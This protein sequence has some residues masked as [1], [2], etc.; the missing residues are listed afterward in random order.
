MKSKNLYVFLGNSVEGYELFKHKS[1]RFESYY[2]V[3]QDITG[4][5][6]YSS[7]TN[8][9]NF[10]NNDSMQELIMNLMP[11]K[12][13]VIY[14]LLQSLLIKDIEQELDNLLRKVFLITKMMYLPIIHYR[15]SKIWFLDESLLLIKKGNSHLAEKNSLYSFSAGLEVFIK[16]AAL[17][18]AKKNINVNLIQINELNYHEKLESLLSIVSDNNKLYLTAQKLSI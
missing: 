18:L 13:I 16:V 4:I 15:E 17:E 11:I 1:S 9:V 7:N 10:T 14:P 12:N 5:N 3:D 2:L 6:N 8:V